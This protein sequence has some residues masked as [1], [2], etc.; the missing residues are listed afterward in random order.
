MANILVGSSNV[1]RFY[2]S[3][4]F[5]EIRQY[6]MVRCTEETSFKAFLEDIEDKSN[7]V[8]STIENFITA[9][10]RD[11]KQDIKTIA[12]NTVKEFLACVGGAAT[13]HPDSKF[14]IVMPLQRP[15]VKWY[16]QHLST[17]EGAMSEGITRMKKDNVVKIDCISSLSQIFESDGVHLTPQSGKCFLEIALEQAEVFFKAQVVNIDEDGELGD[18]E[19]E[20][21]TLGR[22][23]AAETSSGSASASRSVESRGLRDTNNR[24]SKLE[25]EMMR[26]KLADNLMFARIRE[27][28]DAAANKS[29]EDRVVI[30][31]LVSKLPLPVDHKER[32]ERLREMAME[33][34]NFLIPDFQGKISF[35]SL[36]KGNGKV[37]PMLEVRLELVESAAAIRKSFAEKNKQKLLTGDYERLFISNS[38]S[39]ATRVRIDILKAIAKKIT[40]DDDQAYVVGFISRPIMHLR[41]RS[42]AR[43]TKPHKSYT[44]VDAVENFGQQ[45]YASDLESAYN[46]AGKAFKG[47]L[48]QNFIVLHDEKQVEWERSDFYST[49]TSGGY[50]GRGAR[51]SGTPRGRGDGHRTSSLK[52]HGEALENVRKR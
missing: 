19:D 8:I 36:G 50:S 25:A 30:S 6:T 27:E 18:E 1:V 45:I 21:Q 47:Q 9:R 49:R 41:K 33:I 10:V 44:F 23:K 28:M 34:F 43:N 15:A 17:I 38:V 22:K 2:R 3:G 52:R 48:Q 35:V 24:L 42:A 20:V 4:S 12:T 32:I 46:R 39:L 11:D 14:A 37:I 31:G 29:K 26:R 7:V 16:Q 40:T 5:P 13:K 51:G